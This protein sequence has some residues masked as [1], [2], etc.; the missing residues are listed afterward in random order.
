LVIPE[1]ETDA[2]KAWLV[3]PDEDEDLLFEFELPHIV[4]S[5]RGVSFLNLTLHA[6]TNREAA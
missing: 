3:D 2:H 4:M 6:P 1:W 5:G